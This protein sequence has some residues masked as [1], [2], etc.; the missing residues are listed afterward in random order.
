MIKIISK[1]IRK[2]VKGKKKKIGFCE[3][4]DKRIIEASRY[5][6]DNDLVEPVL[7]G[8]DIEGKKELFGIDISDLEKH[9]TSDEKYIKEFSELR[10][11]S[12]DVSKEKMKDATYY[13]T[14]LL[15]DSEIDGL[16][17]GADHST[18][19]TLRPALKIIKGKDYFDG[20]VS[21]FFIMEKEDQVYFMSDCAMNPNPSESQL[22]NIALQTAKSA[23]LFIDKPRVA[24]LSFSTNSSSNHHMA[25]K[26][27]NALN[28]TIKRNKDFKINAEFDGEMQ[29][30]CAISE[31]VA[32]K[33]YPE[34][35]IAGN[36]NVLIFPDL[37]SGNIGYKLVERF[38]NFKAVGPI[39]QGLNKPANDLSRGAKVDDIIDVA[40]ITAFQCEELK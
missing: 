25:K 11:V 19:H 2:K 1:E 38:A 16:V 24:M 14:M 6:K 35:N 39:L 9:N 22:S 40:C 26:V 3:T 31:K 37:N 33:K 8:K 36:A 7:I 12:F 30:D 4:E 29:L 10:N 17:S 13:A 20:F 34:S 32:K 28:M 27:K 21:S 18:E 5:L 23:S 15:H